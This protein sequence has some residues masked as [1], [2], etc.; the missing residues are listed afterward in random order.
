MRSGH[1]WNRYPPAQGDQTAS[2]AHLAGDPQR[3]LLRAAQRLFLAHPPQGPPSLADCL[4][5]PTSGVGSQIGP[6]SGSTPSCG[7]GLRRRAD[8]TP[9]TPSAAILAGQPIGPNE[10]KRERGY[11][12]AKLLMGREKAPAICWLVGTLG[13][14]LTVKVTPADRNDRE[15]GRRVL[16]AIEGCFP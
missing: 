2:Q 12:G 8:A 7:S 6:G 3:D 13:L 5:L 1:F 11:D 15:G 4:H 16:E 9:P 10:R 14:F